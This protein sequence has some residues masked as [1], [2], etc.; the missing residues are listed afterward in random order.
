M[1][2][3]ILKDLSDAGKQYIKTS[4]TNIYGIKICGFYW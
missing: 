1:D 3:K 2:L 4:I